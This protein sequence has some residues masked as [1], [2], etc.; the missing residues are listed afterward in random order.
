LIWYFVYENVEKNYLNINS[1]SAPDMTCYMYNKCTCIIGFLQAFALCSWI[2]CMYIFACQASS[3]PPTHY[4]TRN[5]DLLYKFV[6]SFRASWLTIKY[7]LLLLYIRVITKQPEN[8]E[9]RNDPDLVIRINFVSGKSQSK[10][11]SLHS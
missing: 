11:G 8:C 9:N 2:I 1:K 7:V 10:K 5:Y 4:P 3:F 6:C